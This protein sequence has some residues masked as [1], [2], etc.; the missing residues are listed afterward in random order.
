VRLVRHPL[1]LEGVV[2]SAP[3]VIHFHPARGAKIDTARGRRG[4]GG[5]QSYRFALQAACASACRNSRR[6]FHQFAASV[7]SSSERNLSHACTGS[8]PAS[9]R[10][11]PQ[12]FRPGSFCWRRA[13]GGAGQVARGLPVGK[14]D[15][16][17]CSELDIASRETVS[18]QTFATSSWIMPCT[19]LRLETSFCTATDSI[20]R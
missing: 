12:M 10:L 7:P 6:P 13:R 1:I 5:S 8:P 18:K 2:L 16:D 9:A 15:R 17:I 3:S 20:R 11:S 4:E 14:N 19:T